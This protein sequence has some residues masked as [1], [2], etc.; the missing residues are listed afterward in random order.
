MIHVTIEGDGIYEHLRMPVVPRKGEVLW[1]TSLIGHSER[2]PNEV[3]VSKVTWA[4]DQTVR[5]TDKEHEGI[6]VRLTVRRINK[7]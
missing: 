3:L 7:T 6:R 2:I 5:Y 4:R 1:L